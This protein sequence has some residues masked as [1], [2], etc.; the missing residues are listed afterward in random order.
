MTSG[1]RV[2][3]VG[4]G[5]ATV[6]AVH[7]MATPLVLLGAPALGA[8][9]EGPVEWALIA[10]AAALAGVS[11]WRLAR[12]DGGGTTASVMFTGVAMLGLGVTLGE[13]WLGRAVVVF[14]GVLLAG[15]HL[16][17]GRVALG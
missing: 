4:V 12:R 16:R 14:A 3:R 15:A 13:S 17:A 1:S 6:C 10:G 9:L 2:D 11:G 7:C 5:V 8:V